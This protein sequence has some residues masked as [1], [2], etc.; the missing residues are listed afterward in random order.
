MSEATTKGAHL[1]AFAGE[2]FD[3]VAP[4]AGDILS[5]AA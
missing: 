4:G 5:A 2:D 1:L 3:F